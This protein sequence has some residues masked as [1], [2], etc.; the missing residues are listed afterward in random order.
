MMGF[1]QVARWPK[2]QRKCWDVGRRFPW[3]WVFATVCPAPNAGAPNWADLPAPAPPAGQLLPGRRG[4]GV[5]G[6]VE[7][8]KLVP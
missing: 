3:T 4:A 6:P 5:A 1:G 8:T 7:K 2:E